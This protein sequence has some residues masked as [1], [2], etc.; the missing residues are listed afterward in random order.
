MYTEY[1]SYAPYELLK[2]HSQ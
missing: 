2:M 1:L